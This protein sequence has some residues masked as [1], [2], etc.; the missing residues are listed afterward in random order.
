[1]SSTSGAVDTEVQQLSGLDQ[2]CKLIHESRGQR[3][4]KS[5]RVQGRREEIGPGTTGWTAK[6]DDAAVC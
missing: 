6:N 5:T 4:Y 3:M 1:M 2:R